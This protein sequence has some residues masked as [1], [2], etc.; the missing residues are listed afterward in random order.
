MSA[1]SIRLQ[2]PSLHKSVNADKTYIYVANEQ[3][4]RRLN[5]F[6]FTRTCICNDFGKPESTFSTGC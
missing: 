6:R 2:V 3:T 5:T 1:Y 4:F